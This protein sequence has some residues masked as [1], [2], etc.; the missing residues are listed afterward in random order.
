MIR[1][2]R[3]IEERREAETESGRALGERKERGVNDKAKAKEVKRRLALH[4]RQC[5]PLV[6]PSS[7]TL[8]SNSPPAFPHSASRQILFRLSRTETNSKPRSLCRFA[9]PH[10]AR[11]R[12]RQR[13][14][15]GRLRR[16]WKHRSGY[17]A[18]IAALLERQTRKRAAAVQ[19]K[20]AS[21]C[22][23]PWE[24]H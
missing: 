9:S 2:Q 24:C 4:T 23:D 8:P 1:K 21:G 12:K 11:L 10:H 7:P 17:T 19:A 16:P 22:D 15:L 18:S 3:S 5:L 6:S 13:H 14:A 20:V